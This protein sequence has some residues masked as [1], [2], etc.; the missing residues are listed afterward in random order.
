MA[1][2]IISGINLRLTWNGTKHTLFKVHFTGELKPTKDD[3]W[4]KK[5][6]G[7]ALWEATCK[8]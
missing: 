7:N 8:I 2:K 6:R 4:R 3:L 1:L 5:E